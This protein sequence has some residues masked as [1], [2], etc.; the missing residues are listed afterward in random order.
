MQS[1]FGQWFCQKHPHLPMW[2]RVDPCGSASCR[3][4]TRTSFTFK[5]LKNPTF[6]HVCAH[7]AVIVTCYYVDLILNFKNELILKLSKNPTFANVSACRPFCTCLL[8]TSNLNTYLRRNLEKTPHLCMY[9]R[10]EAHRVTYMLLIMMIM[11]LYALILKSLKN[12][13][14]A[15]VSACYPPGTLNTFWLLDRI[16]GPW[17]WQDGP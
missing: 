4:P 13:A 6:A 17:T 8:S 7:M 15:H 12:P 3:R 10:P 11:F 16:L 5:T 2:V 14:F 1:E 9:T